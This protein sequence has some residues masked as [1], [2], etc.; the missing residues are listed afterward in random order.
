MIGPFMRVAMVCP[1]SLSRP[2]GVQGQAAGLARSLRQLGH[3]VALLGPDGAGPLA[4]GGGPFDGT[5]SIGRSVAVRANGSVAPVA[6]SPSAALRLSRFASRHRADVVHLH[7]PLAPVAGYGSLLLRPAPTVG[8]Y[9]RAGA[10]RWFSVLRPVAHWA[11]GRLDVAC[12]VSAEAAATAGAVTGRDCEVLFNGVEVDRFAGA[13]PWP[14]EAPT[15]LFLGRHEP[16]KGLAM[17][18]DAFTAVPDPAI[19]WVAGDGPETLELKRRHPSGERIRWLGLLSD[20]EVARRLAGADVLC[21]PSLWGESFG[22]VLLEAM[23]AGCAV[24]AS[25]IPGYRAAAGGHASLVAP[26]DP[27]ALGRALT[28]AV[29]GVVGSCGSSEPDLLR[30][31]FDHA[32]GWSMDR[33]ATRYV[34]LYRRAAERWSATTGRRRRP[35][36]VSGR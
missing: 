18:L 13:E 11:D 33:L 1:Y 3:E 10:S 28:Q 17:L 31:A 5:W 14:T 2:G 16:R 29:A 7:E 20:D 4:T 34:A 32:E 22:M 26:G 19:L 25:D 36:I 21:A 23:A 27:G 12:A 15:V 6:L 24:V 35:G 30:A 9:H 8:T